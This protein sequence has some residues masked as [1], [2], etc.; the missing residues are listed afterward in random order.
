M[1][2]YSYR[3]LEMQLTQQYLTTTSGHL[4]TSWFP[5]YRAT[6]ALRRMDDWK[7]R[8]YIR[9]KQ[10]HTNIHPQPP[11][12]NTR[13]G[14]AHLKFS[15][16]V[17]CVKSFCVFLSWYHLSCRALDGLCIWAKG[18]SNV[19]WAF[20]RSPLLAGEE[21]KAAVSQELVHH[22]QQRYRYS[23]SQSKIN[24]SFSLQP[25]SSKK[26]DITALLFN[27]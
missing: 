5:L 27:I 11:R 21:V 25:S 12:F 13:L 15:Q 17:P 26:I 23:A 7:Q 6:V 24:I 19:H 16:R 1:D 3:V 8:N 22:L 14:R 20:P 9:I 2:P 10:T 18:S 4:W